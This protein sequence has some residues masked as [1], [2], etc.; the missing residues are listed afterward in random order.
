MKKPLS[1][2]INSFRYAFR[3]IRYMFLSQTNAKIHLFFALM[4]VIL[5]VAL[6]LWWVEWLLC[7]LCIAMVFSAE[8]FNSALEVLTDLVHPAQHPQ[9]G[10]AKDIAAGAVLITALVSAMIGLIIFL[11]KIYLLF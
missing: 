2:R 6:Q 3:G 11:P 4:V 7:L 8:A 1:K 10:L 9:A 5:G